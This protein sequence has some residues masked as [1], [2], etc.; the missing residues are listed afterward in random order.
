MSLDKLS[1]AV[2]I[3]GIVD[4]GSSETEGNRPGEVSGLS[5]VQV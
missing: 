3:E 2:D 5:L 1:G 4:E